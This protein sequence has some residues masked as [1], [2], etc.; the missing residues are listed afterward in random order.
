[1][2]L[3]DLIQK[4][5]YYQG[6]GS[7]ESDLDKINKIFATAKEG[8][9]TVLALKK[10]IG[11]IEK[12]KLEAAKIKG[13]SVTPVGQ[14]PGMGNVPSQ[15]EQDAENKANREK[16]EAS[17]NLQKQ[18][19]DAD[20]KRMAAEFFK[21]SGPAGTTT[22]QLAADNPFVEPQPPEEVRVREEFFKKY[23]TMNP[24][25]SLD[26]NV[27]LGKLTGQVWVNPNN[28][29]DISFEPRTGW[30]SAKPGQALSAIASTERQERSEDFRLKTIQI[31]EELRQSYEERQL[32]RQELKEVRP[33]YNSLDAS[34]SKGEILAKDLKTAIANRW[35]VTG[36]LSVSI[37]TFKEV[38]GTMPAE[39]QALLTRLRLNFA[40]FVR[41]RG[42]T[43][44]TETEK[45]NF[46]PI[47]PEENKDE[48]TNLNR[49]VT[50][51]DFYKD[52]KNQLA[53][54][55][56]GLSA[57]EQ[58]G[59]KQTQKT[60]GEGRKLTIEDYKRAVPVGVTTTS[61]AK[62]ALKLAYPNLSDEE[63]DSIVDQLK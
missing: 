20:L 47:M 23:P 62:G 10:A 57:I 60:A 12:N 9:T 39:Q 32:I 19:Y 14:F 51:I 53:S 16:F 55:Y 48:T 63:L 31:Q 38:I 22:G 5:A 8:G 1:M 15:A 18:Q 17:R 30:I 56:P 44:F 61:A 36:L 24:D 40:D 33:Q 41:E 27:K 21:G 13:E 37:N 59:N 46:A 29:S 34:I 45:Q 35:N 25:I 50:L 7:D 6:G 58:R 52:R 4:L 54:N 2:A 49:I 43:A 28:V 42:G 3:A 26:Q 11:D